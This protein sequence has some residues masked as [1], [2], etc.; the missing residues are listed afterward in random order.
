MCAGIVCIYV[1]C[2]I[3]TM[4]YASVIV[5]LV[6]LYLDFET[7]VLTFDERM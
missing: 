6:S 2:I 5:M 7:T 1:S 4:M 3:L